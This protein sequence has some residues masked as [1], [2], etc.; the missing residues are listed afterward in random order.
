MSPIQPNQRNLTLKLLRIVG[1]PFTHEREC[2]ASR[3]ETLDLYK[4]ATKNKI[5]FTYLESLKKLELLKKLGFEAEYEKEQ[6]K[7]KEQ[8]STAIRISKILDSLH[9]D[10][11]IFKS[12]MP[13]PA[14]Q[15]D[16]DIIIF[17]LDDDYR[18]L[19]EKLTEY[20]YIDL[21]NLYADKVR[22]KHD[23][24]THQFHDA[25]SNMHKSISV[26]DVYDLDLYQEISLMDYIIYLDKKVFQKYVTTM[27]ILN[28]QIK[29][30]KPEA[31]LTA[32]IAHSTLKEQIFTLHTYYAVLHHLAKMD[33]KQ[34][35]DFITIAER[36]N[37]IT[38]V[39]ACCSM[40]ARLHNF[41][42]NFYP[43]KLSDIIE[44]LGYERK[45]TEKLIKKDL[46][47]P[48]HFSLSLITKAFLDI[49]KDRMVQKS[50]ARQVQGMINPTGIKRALTGLICLRTRDT[51]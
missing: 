20:G 8:L 30:L 25:R 16:I 6:E 46:E 34:I 39:R 51:Y 40:T 13:F 5:G 43:E 10:H 37:V 1:S 23:A 49:A 33:S 50:I 35:K 4:Y 12:I 18:I 15:N 45:E 2:P 44:I 9:V 14:I 17:G 29:V 7:Y 48:Y 28:H 36:S 31:E 19:I 32:I 27:N 11:V 38:S 21:R 3:R 26:K 41:A 24:L 22:D 42:Y 47:M